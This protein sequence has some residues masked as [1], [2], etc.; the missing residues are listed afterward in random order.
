MGKENKIDFKLLKK[1]SQEEW[2]IEHT[3]AKPFFISPHVRA[4]VRGLHPAAYSII[5]NYYREGEM[6][7]MT[8]IKEQ[9]K[10]YEKVINKQKEDNNYW[11]KVFKKWLKKEEE[12]RKFYN[13]LVAKNIRIIPDKK[14]IGDI[15]KYVSFVDVSRR[16]SSIIDPFTF[17]VETEFKKML[18][19]FGEKSKIDINE[20]Y[21]IL[22]RPEF[23]SFFNARDIE[24]ADLAKNILRKG[25]KIIPESL[26]SKEIYKKIQ[27]HIKKYSWIKMNSFTDGGKAYGFNEVFKEIRKIAREKPNKIIRKNKEYLINRQKRRN[28]IRKYKFNKEIVMVSNLIILFTNWQDIRKEN[29]LMASYLNNK[30]FQEIARRKKIKKD[31]VAYLDY[32]EIGDLLEG[33]LKVSE[34]EK[35]KKGVLFAFKKDSFKIFTDKKILKLILDNIIN[36]KIEKTE[37]KGTSASL[38]NVIGRV[39]IIRSIRDLK[40]MKKGDILITTMTRPEH[41]V[42]IKKAKA[43]VTDDGGITCHAAIVSRELGIP[44]I[45]G[46][47]VATKTLKDGDKIEVD[48]K[49]GIVKILKRSK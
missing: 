39:T 21:D 29:S 28:Y 38:G 18:V 19:K 12:F 22:T 32:S 2:Y 44:C 23:P 34:I 41:I 20:A 26:K 43:I 10:L 35:R 16:F 31:V 14:L 1:L 4:F 37:I 49:K 27:S 13:K 6:D 7:W 11:Q 17:I 47:R 24:L 8:L 25:K 46:T 48:A 33:N 36:K 30:Y 3:D 42:A 9:I 40:N 5:L 45:I 15:K